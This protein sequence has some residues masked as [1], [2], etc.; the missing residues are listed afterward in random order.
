MKE[1]TKLRELVQSDDNL[2]VAEIADEALDLIESIDA[3]SVSKDSKYITYGD[4]P[5]D[6]VDEFREEGRKESLPY[7]NIDDEAKHDLFLKYMPCFRWSELN[8]MFKMAWKRKKV[9]N[10]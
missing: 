5:D 6:V 4:V 1:I 2:Y 10:H 8:F 9:I 7:E 3:N